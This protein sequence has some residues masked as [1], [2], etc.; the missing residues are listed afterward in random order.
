MVFNVVY[1]MAPDQRRHVSINSARWLPDPGMGL[2]YGTNKG[3]LVICRPVFYR[4]DGESPA[5]SSSE[6][7]FSVN[8]SGTSRTRGSDRPGPNRS[9]WRLDR[10]MGLMNAIG[11]QPRHPAPSVTSQG[12]QTPIIQLQNAE[13]QT[14]RDLSE[15]SAPQLAANVPPE[16]PSTS[17]ATPGQPEASQSGRAAD[18]SQGEASAEANASTASTES[19][20]F[21]TGEDALARIRRLIA[22]GGMTAVV[23][24]EQS[25]TMASMGGFGNNI[26][27]SHRI[28][29]GSQ[30]GAGASRPA[31]HP[32]LT[33]TSTSGPLLV[34]QTYTPPP[35]EQLAPMWGPQV[36]SPPQPPGISLVDMDDVFDGGQTDDDSLP[37]PSSSLLLS[38][39]SL[40]SSSSSHSPLPGSGGGGGASNSYPGDPYS[41]VSR[42]E[43]KGHK[44]PPAPELS[45]ASSGEVPP[46]LD[47]H[48]TFRKKLC[49]LPWGAQEGAGLG[50]S[51]GVHF[52]CTCTGLKLNRDHS[53]SERAST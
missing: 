30:T 24:R 10:D 6:P 46:P 45:V 32:T 25:T 36:L 14:E 17:R 27:V 53:S 7:L 1:P 19:P 49:T 42:L 8:N 34:T 21:G 41:R 15:P 29:R 38:S 2:A 9:G 43:K 3:D 37:G 31:A 23:Q 12:T 28:H 13:T 35:S 48:G 52:L 11:L 18:G 26:I 20:E 22:E 44:N 51:V 4:S 16:T 33:A 47:H 39:S 50:L 40:S 5:E